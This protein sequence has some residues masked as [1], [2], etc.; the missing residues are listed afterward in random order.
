MRTVATYESAPER[1]PYVPSAHCTP[2]SIPA[3]GGRILRAM[4][5]DVPRELLPLADQL[6]LIDRRLEAAPG[7]VRL[8]PIRRSLW[9]WL[10][11]PADVVMV[12]ADLL[13]S[14]QTEVLLLLP[15]PIGTLDEMTLRVAA[16]GLVVD[17]KAISIICDMIEGRP[18]RRRQRSST[19]LDLA[20]QAG[21]LWRWRRLYAARA[22]ANAPQGPELAGSN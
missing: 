20:D 8:H 21:R 22:R 1:P 9:R 15:V 2:I 18:I 14:P 7:R 6:R 10:L 16:H 12:L 4:P 13:A 5:L 11:M 17:M 19:E 3:F